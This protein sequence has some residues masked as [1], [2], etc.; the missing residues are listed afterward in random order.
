MLYGHIFILHGFCL[1]LGRVQGGN[2]AGVGVDPV[3]VYAAADTGELLQLRLGGGLKAFH[4]Y[5]HFF[6]KLRHQ[7]VLLL[8]ES[9]QQV[10]LLQL[11]V[12][13]LSHQLLSGLDSLFG[14]SGI[15]IEIHSHPSF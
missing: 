6:Q 9:H 2:Q 15:D 14:F 10:N 13:V 3:E 12:V 5:V 8:Q 11:G 7:P 1:I 4:G